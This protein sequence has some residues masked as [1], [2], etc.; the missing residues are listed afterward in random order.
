MKDYNWA[1]DTQRLKLIRDPTVDALPK[2][3][4]YK[5][6]NF[7]QIKNALNRCDNLIKSFVKF[8]NFEACTEIKKLRE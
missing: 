1:T 7:V 2:D 5:Q 3:F 8:Q 4:K 6:L